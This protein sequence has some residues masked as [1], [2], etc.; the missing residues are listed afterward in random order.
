MAKQSNARELLEKKA[1]KDRI[2]SAVLDDPKSIADLIEI[3]HE[4]KGTLRYSSE[5]ILRAISETDPDLI[6][7]YFE[8][9][10]DLLDAENS[11]LK[12][13]AIIIIS[14]LVGVDEDRRFDSISNRYF[15]PMQGPVLV[16]AAN[17]VSNAWKI[18]MARPDLSDMIVSRLLSVENA[19][20]IN[21][22]S[23]SNECNNI[24]RGKAIESFANF[25]DDIRD[26]DSVIAFVERQLDNSRNAVTKK[27]EKFLRKYA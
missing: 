22:G 16:T 13:G 5:K 1:D 6:Y 17:I 10:A 2:F 7:P 19:E 26:K 25:Y 18:A 8:T 4:K 3:L 15:A 27:A 23:P 12:W 9:F 24:I 21:K 20:F 14:N 11:F